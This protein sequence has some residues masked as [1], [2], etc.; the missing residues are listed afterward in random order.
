[1]NH[2]SAARVLRGPSSAEPGPPARLARERRWRRLKPTR[3]IV[4]VVYGKPFQCG[5]PKI[6]KLVCNSNN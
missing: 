1:M 3:R 2:S 5:A 6:A 4:T